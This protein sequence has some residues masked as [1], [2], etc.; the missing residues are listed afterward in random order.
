MRNELTFWLARLHRAYHTVAWEELREHGYH[1]VQEWLMLELWDAG[2]VRFSTLRRRLGVSSASLS[3][4]VRR[5]SR[6]LLV[7]VSGEPADKRDALVRSSRLARMGEPEVRAT[8]RYIEEQMWRDLSDE[9][10][11]SFARLLRRAA[12]AATRG[13]ERTRRVRAWKGPIPDRWA[14]EIW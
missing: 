4:T 3:R 10:R 14:A 6:E 5:L 13:A 8:V 2:S 9:E 1:P 7:E 11:A 12:H